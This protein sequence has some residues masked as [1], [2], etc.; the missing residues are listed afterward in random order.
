MNIIHHNLPMS[1]YRGME[2][3]SKHQFDWFIQAPAYYQWR[4]TQDFK[5]SRD[6]ILGTLI[7]AQALEGRKEY[8]IGPAV[9]RRTKAGKADWEAF[10]FDNAGKEV[11]NEEEGARIEGAVAAAEI[12][13]AELGFNAKTASDEQMEWVEASMFWTDDQHPGLQFKGRPDLI[14]PPSAKRNKTTIVDLKTTSDFF[15][16]TRKFWDL[17]YD[18]QACWY[19]WGLHKLGHH[20]VEFIF[21]V[22]DTEQPH[23]GQLMS[24]DGSVLDHGYR[25]MHHNLRNFRCCTDVDEW[26]APSGV[27]VLTR[28]HASYGMGSPA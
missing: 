2:G 14:I 27:R 11:V 8:A 23:F 9:D 16:F 26:P 5:P 6:M 15:K 22:V 4:K 10:C 20:D 28:Y 3:L 17:H 12:L 25:T 18:R 21:A 1:D 7:H 24:V 13:L 19:S